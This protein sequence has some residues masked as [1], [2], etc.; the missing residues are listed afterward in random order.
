MNLSPSSRRIFSRISRTLRF[1]FW[2]VI[3][4]HSIKNTKGSEEPSMIGTSA[5]STSIIKLSIPQLQIA[6]IKCSIVEIEAPNSLAIEV[7][8]LVVVTFLK[9]ALISFLP[10]SKSILWKTM[11]ELIGAGLIFILIFKPLCRPTELQL[12]EL[13]IVF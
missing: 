9:S 5:L 6:A 10:D 13:L 7:P 4:A 8:R 1:S 3:P 2:E 11:P 12:I